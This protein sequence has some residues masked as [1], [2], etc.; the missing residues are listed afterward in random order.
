MPDP[1]RTR[2]MCCVQRVMHRQRLLADG[3]SQAATNSD[4]TGRQSLKVGRLGVQRHT[5][6]CPV[7]PLG[8]VD[9]NNPYRKPPM[10]QKAT[11]FVGWNRDGRKSVALRNIAAL[12]VVLLGSLYGYTRYGGE[13]N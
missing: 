2:A 10:S 6:R 13:A 4:P 11:M 7:T 3:S 5:D 1:E 9:D 8:L 12:A